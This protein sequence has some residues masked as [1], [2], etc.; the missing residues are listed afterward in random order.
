MRQNEKE[1]DYTFFLLIAIIL[2][3]CLFFGL[4]S[5][6]KVD[7]PS[8][9][10]IEVGTEYNTSAKV[11]FLGIDFSWFVKPDQE[12]NTEVVGDYTVKY[13]TFFGT[14]LFE[15]TYKVR[16]TLDPE[17]SLVGE[18][19]VIVQ[20]LEDFVDPGAVAVDNYDGDISSKI[21]TSIVNK[22]SSGFDVFYAA[23]DSSGNIST[24][25]RTVKVV[26]GTVYLTFDDGPSL[27]ITPKILD[28]L[29]EKNVSATFFVVG[30][31]ESKYPLL[32]RMVDEGHTI[33]LHGYSHEYSKIY[34]SIDTLMENFY[35]LE[36]RVSEA[37]DGY[38][39]KFIRFPGGSSNTVS[40]SFCTGI[41][42]EATS[43]VEEQGYTYFDWNVDSR[44]AGGAKT[45]EEVYNNVI[46]GIS[47]GTNIVLMHDSSGHTYTLEAL[48]AIID[49]CIANNYELK[50]ID[51]ETKTIHH[52]TAN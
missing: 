15:H 50:A 19:V 17:I 31:G 25:L 11:K 35:K 18:K 43:L 51:S 21:S 48:E 52:K 27:D 45:A 4:R 47:P 26:Q 24:I 36:K 7:I 23:T 12:I 39:S 46:Q 49:Y 38:E 42:T 2:L 3:V 37:T 10:F 9:D 1:K 30:F 16:D 40:R 13:K 28:I 34:T 29:K 41:M 33:G 14:N 6:L 22:S 44:D 32:K 5:T 20:K 8:Q